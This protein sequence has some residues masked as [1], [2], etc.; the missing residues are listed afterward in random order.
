MGG[1]GGQAAVGAWDPVSRGAGAFGEQVGIRL[2][3]G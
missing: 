2:S 1:G 3:F